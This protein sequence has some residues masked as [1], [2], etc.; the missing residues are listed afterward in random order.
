MTPVIDACIENLTS[1]G[2]VRP[3]IGPMPITM[4]LFLKR[5]DE[6]S[7]RVICDLRPL[8]AL[9]T[10][11]PPGSNCLP[12]LSS[13]EI[14]HWEDCLFTKL[15]ITAY[16]HSLTLRLK[17]YCACSLPPI[18]IIPLCFITV[19]AAGFGLVYPLAGAGLPL[20]PKLIWSTKLHLL[21]SYTPTFW[22]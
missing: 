12:L 22:Y 3:V 19:V 11:S 8:N 20:L 17:I 4:Q 21:L 18:L 15:D 1:E 13:S 2:I 5:K 7:S 14:T 6:Y 9:Y 16:Y 10:T